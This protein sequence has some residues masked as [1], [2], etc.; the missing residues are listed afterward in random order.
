MAPRQMAAVKK[1]DVDPA[2]QNGAG[3]PIDIGMLDDWVGFHLRMA[4]IAS[5]Q[6]FARHAQ[7]IEAQSGPLCSTGVDRS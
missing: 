5:F 6:S 2:A 4:Q 3:E 1:G 7:G